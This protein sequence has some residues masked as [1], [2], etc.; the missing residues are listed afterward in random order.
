MAPKEG[1]RYFLFGNELVDEALRGVHL[2][3]N[4]ILIV[5]NTYCRFGEPTRVI[6][7]HNPI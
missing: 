6:R 4:V 7:Q 5:T 1:P 3:S 2:E